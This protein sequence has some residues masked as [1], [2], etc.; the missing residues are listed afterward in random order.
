MMVDLVINDLS[1]FSLYLAI[2]LKKTN[3]INVVKLSE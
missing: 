3:K 2:Y 1:Y